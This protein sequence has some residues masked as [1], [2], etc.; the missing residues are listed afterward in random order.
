MAPAPI[1]GR[2]SAGIDKAQTLPASS[3]RVS[4][5]EWDLQGS[6]NNVLALSSATHKVELRTNKCAAGRDCDLATQCSA[7]EGAAMG[8][9]NWTAP[10]T[11][12]MPPE[13]ELTL[14]TGL[15]AND[16]RVTLVVQVRHEEDVPLA[17]L[18]AASST[19]RM[20]DEDEEGLRE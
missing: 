14:Q 9:C 5:R 15:N 1:T 11:L 12:E 6:R 2:S 8:V 3:V 16:A 10:D 20:H 4:V 19:E 7:S 18:S 17:R 13:F